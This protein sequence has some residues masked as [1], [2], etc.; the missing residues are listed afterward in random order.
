MIKN[1][2]SRWCSFCWASSGCFFSLVTREKLNYLLADAIEICAEFDEY[3][4]RNA[5]TFADKSEKNMFGA[6]VVVSE[7][8][9]F[10][11]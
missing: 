6:D 8:E 3:L 2:R 10:A 11:K 4:G 7:L 1:E 5:F 9:R